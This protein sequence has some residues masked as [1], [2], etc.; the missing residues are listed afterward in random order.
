VRPPKLKRL[1]NPHYPVLAMKM[2]REAQV[3]VM[4]LV[5]ENGKVLEARLRDPKKKGYGFDE[6]A[7]KAARQALFTPATKAGVPVKI[8]STIRVEFELK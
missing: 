6:A 2:R 3:V 8:W 5:D 7:L 1:P 4:V